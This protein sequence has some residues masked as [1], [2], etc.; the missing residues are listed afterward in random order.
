MSAPELWR[1]EPPLVDRREILRYAG[2]RGD[3]PE[4]SAR[5]EECL[6]A[7]WQGMTYSVVFCELPVSELPLGESKSLSDRLAGC[8]RAVIF[9]ATVGLEPD[10]RILRYGSREPSRALLCQAIGT[11]RVEALCDAFCDSLAE[12]YGKE[13]CVPRPRFSPGYGDCPL[14]LQRELLLRLDASRRI[15]VTLNKSLL[16]TPTKSVTA[17]VGIGKV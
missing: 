14:S 4:I 10:R 8:E 7:M 12:K 16:M 2:V 3:A 6:S 13:G 5:L 17:I 9:A 11:E 15:G 1:I